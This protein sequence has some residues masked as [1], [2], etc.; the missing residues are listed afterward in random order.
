MS[1]K[2]KTI[3]LIASFLL[4]ILTSGCTQYIDQ[5]AEK[6]YCKQLE[7]SL[8]QEGQNC[9]C[10]Q[11]KNIPKGLENESV[12]PKCACSC[13]I[14]GTRYNVSIVQSEE[15]EETRLLHNLSK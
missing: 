7:E 1:R 4:L 8:K 15:V 13:L 9:I 11:S 12:S 2:I 3:V 5:P 10:Y 14:N 6:S